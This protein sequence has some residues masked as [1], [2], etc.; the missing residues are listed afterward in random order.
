MGSVFDDRDCQYVMIA[1]VPRL[2]VSLAEPLDLLN[3]VDLEDI[4][5]RR[6]RF[7]EEGYEDCP[8]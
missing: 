3:I 2:L 1:Q 8:L 5:A 6:L 7:K 4:G